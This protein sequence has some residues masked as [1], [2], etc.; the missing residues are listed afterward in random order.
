M[1][2]IY[3]IGEIAAAEGIG[4]GRVRG[5]WRVEAG[6][7]WRTVEGQTEGKLREVETAAGTAVFNE[8]LDFQMSFSS[9]QKWPRIS[10][11]IFDSVGRRVLSV[12]ALIPSE[13][14]FHEMKVTGVEGGDILINLDIVF[15]AM[16]TNGW[17]SGFD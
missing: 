7:A 15:S 4:S 8:V 6:D 3:V 2:Q 9:P 11:E 16:E 1:P 5:Y 12:S 17:R 14:G 10:I 13:N